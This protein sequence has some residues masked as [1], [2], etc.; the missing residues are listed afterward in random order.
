MNSDISTIHSAETVVDI[1]RS[2]IYL[3]FMCVQVERDHIR[4]T[5]VAF[6]DPCLRMKYCHLSHTGFGRWSGKGS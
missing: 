3:C 4:P 5:L 2:I 1:Y 6:Y